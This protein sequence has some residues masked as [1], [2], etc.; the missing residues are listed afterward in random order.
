MSVFDRTV[1]DTLKHDLHDF[2][3][4]KI[5]IHGEEHAKY[6]LSAFM[7]VAAEIGI[8]FFDQRTTVVLIE[9]L[10]D[11]VSFMGKQ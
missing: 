2:V 7:E 9:S 4:D 10:K 1:T 11:H 6:L 5:H 8:N 3:C